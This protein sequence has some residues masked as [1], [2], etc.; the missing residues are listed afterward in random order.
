M[1]PDEFRLQ[2]YLTRHGESRGNVVSDNGGQYNPPNEHERHN[3][4]LTPRGVEQ[5]GLLAERLR[6]HRF[7]AMFSSPLV[8][9][10]ATAQAVSALQ[11]GEAVPLELL[12]DLTEVGTPW[13]YAGYPPDALI[14]RF[15]GV[16]SLRAL[17]PAEEW[18]AAEVQ[19]PQEA[20]LLRA[21]TCIRYI[22]ERFY[23]GERVFIA[24]HG[25][26]NT[27]LIRAA[28]GLTNVADFNFCQ[29]NTALTKIKYFPD[30]KPRLSYA[31]DTSHL[32]QNKPE[33]T[34]SL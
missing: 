32:F 28:L 19:D 29:E 30:G 24:A 11:P 5:A 14:S 10:V 1:L 16:A 26:F 31:N 12:A 9:A 22:K 20:Y 33:L 21:Q 13:D 23:R 25:S 2:I 34:F 7:D 18:H 15:P 4:E 17:V 8:R 3:P 27:Y 6:L